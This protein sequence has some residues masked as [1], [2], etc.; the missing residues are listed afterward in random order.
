MLEY[1]ERHGT[2][3]MKWD[4]MAE[5]FGS[6]DLLALWVADMDFAVDSHIR[7]AMSDYVASGVFGYYRVPN[8]YYEAFENWQRNEHGLEVERTWIRFSPGVV[9]GFH[10]AVQAFSNP[11][12]AVMISTPVY[13]PFMHAVLNTDR[14]L[15]RAPL[16][17]QN[18]AYRFDFDE[19]ERCIAEHDV[20]AYLLCSP[21]NPV[22]RV[23]HNDELQRI[24]DICREHQVVVVS[25]EIHQDLVFGD[26]VHTPTL[27]L[28]R[29]GDQVVM[30]TA[31]SK[32]FN[33]A[34]LQ[35]SFVVVP[36]PV[37]RERWDALAQSLRI[38]QGNPLGYIATQAAYTHGKPWLEEVKATVW[39]NYEYLAS[40]LRQELPQAVVSPLEG[41]YLAWVDFGAYLN[42]EELEEFMQGT[43]KLAFDY[44]SWFGG[45]GEGT[46]V[47]INLATSQDNIAE[48]LRRITGALAQN[49]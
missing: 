15:V 21:H 39:A 24:L 33:I 19:F 13:Y 10:M 43:C 20:K 44:G 37:L 3:S 40:T 42:A 9:V 48:A 18:G 7:K 29:E 31:A 22:G 49:Q 27:S 23:W 25:D 12:D 5:V 17:S 46:H 2:G 32:T 6:N 36:D 1:V 47:R 26:H 14:T 35:N 41:T 30:L 28:S 8:A 38:Q 11:G 45:S 34:G 4:G 16:A